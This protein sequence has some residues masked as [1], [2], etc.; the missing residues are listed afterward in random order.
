MH[1][2]R[3]RGV[4]GGGRGVKVTSR[5]SCPPRSTVLAAHGLA[6]RDR[7]ERKKAK[8]I[9]KTRQEVRLPLITRL[10]AMNGRLESAVDCSRCGRAIG[11]CAGTVL[12]TQAG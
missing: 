2:G 9:G 4:E 8:N 10:R 12:I 7:Q 1:L 6:Y 3:W 5:G 11:L